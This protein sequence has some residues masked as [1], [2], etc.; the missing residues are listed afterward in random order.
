[1]TWI[2]FGAW[3]PLEPR[4]PRSGRKHVCQ[5]LDLFLLAGVP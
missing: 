2:R 3:L 1:V 4:P 5:S